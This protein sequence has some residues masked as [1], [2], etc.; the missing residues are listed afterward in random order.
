MKTIDGVGR[1]NVHSIFNKHFS[2][3]ENLGGPK[4]AG[5]WLSWQVERAGSCVSLVLLEAGS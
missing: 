3:N 4:E 2:P 5:G 1:G